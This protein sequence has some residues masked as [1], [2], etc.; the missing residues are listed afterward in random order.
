[1]LETRVPYVEVIALC[2]YRFWRDVL[3]AAIL[4]SITLTQNVTSA[5][6]PNRY[7]QG[8]IWK[9]AH[10]FYFFSLFS[11]LP[12]LFSLFLPLSLRDLISQTYYFIARNNN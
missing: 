9:A 8:N 1:M 4:E 3:G 11:F 6:S 5:S 12:P 10:W 2:D 7:L